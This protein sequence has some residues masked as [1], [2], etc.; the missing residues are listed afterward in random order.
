MRAF[1]T[2]A[3]FPYTRWHFSVF[4]DWSRVPRG[5]FFGHNG[6][7]PHE[8]HDDGFWRPR[9]F[10]CKSSHGARAVSSNDLLTDGHLKIDNVTP[11]RIDT[12]K[13]RR[14][15]RGCFFG[16]R[17]VRIDS[18]GAA[19]PDASEFGDA[20]RSRCGAASLHRRIRK[21]GEPLTS[22][23]TCRYMGIDIRRRS[24]SFTNLE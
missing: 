17:G 4:S 15:A 11:K 1:P 5:R 19:A 7:R 8:R 22:S 6:V 2:E 20:R 23:A 14:R 21:M 10:F 13:L 9:L 16:V 12:T 3:L 18:R 24:W